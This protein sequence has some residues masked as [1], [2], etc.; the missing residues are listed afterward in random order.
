[1]VTTIQITENLLKKLKIMKIS[2]RDSYE[3]V[4]WDLL[5]DSME[6]SEET[7]KNI[8]KSEEDIRKRR[9]Y[10]WNDV[11]KELKINVRNNSF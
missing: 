8:V 5:E 11:V 3:N 10:K 2:D 7:K 4:I 1:M 9:V 6:L